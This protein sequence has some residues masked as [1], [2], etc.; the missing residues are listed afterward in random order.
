MGSNQ[1]TNVIPSSTPRKFVIL[2]DQRKPKDPRLFLH[3]PPI[4][5]VVILREAED[6]LLPLPHHLRNHSNLLP[7]CP[8]RQ[9][10]RPQHHRL[11]LRKR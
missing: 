6:L 10:Q 2:S 7:L 9:I 4:F 3:F 1:N 11:P 5:P 8:T